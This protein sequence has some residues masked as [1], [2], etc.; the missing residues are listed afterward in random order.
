MWR[1]LP[2]W[3]NLTFSLSLANL[4]FLQA[5]SP[6]FAPGYFQ[7]NANEP[8]SGVAILLN[9]LLLTA[10]FMAARSW[11][12]MRDRGA[13]NVVA[14]II[15]F[16]LLLVPLNSIRFLLNWHYP[17]FSHLLKSPL[18]WTLFLALFLAL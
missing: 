13:W 11:L 5:W 17:Q 10:I 16:L 4:L 3:A 14:A 18:V 9:V 12:G 7:K 1:K 8:F 6:M 2:V 15:L